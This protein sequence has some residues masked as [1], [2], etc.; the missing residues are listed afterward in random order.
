MDFFSAFLQGFQ[1]SLLPLNLGLIL[2]GSCVGTFVATL[3]GIKAIHCVAL[4][5]P[6]AYAL[7]LPVDSALVFLLM[8]YHGGLYGDRITTILAHPGKGN[9]S[10][11]LT[12]TC[13]GSFF[14]GTISLLGLAITMPL[15]NRI[16]IGFG[17]AEYFVLII[18]AFSTLS[19]QA[20]KYP[21]RTLISTCLGLMM[22]TIGIDSTTGILRFTLWQPQLYDGIAFTTVVIGIFVISQIFVLLENPDQHFPAV[23]AKSGFR[24]DWKKLFANRIILL[25]S[26]LCGFLIGTL[27]ACG[28]SIASNL[29][30]TLEKRANAKLPGQQPNKKKLLLARET[31]NNAAAGGT[32]V[33]LLTL[34]IPGS[35]TSAIL[36][37]ALLLYNITPGPTL[38]KQH[39]ELIWTI[40]AAGGIGN[41]VLLILNLSLPRLLIKVHQIPRQITLSFLL[42]LAFIS[43]FSVT[44]SHF[45]L[46]LMVILGLFGYLL[47][48]HHY[49]LVP[50]LLGFV[51]GELMENNLRRAL[52]ISAGE[53]QILFASPICK[54]FW[55]LSLIVILLPLLLRYR[56]GRQ[57]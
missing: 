31:A 47:Q 32:M 21:L 8:I 3:P 41:L 38:L 35:G 53:I 17:P 39:N 46:F 16:N 29:S 50:L 23:K 49:P 9:I 25:R 36:L 44:S 26:A 54:A 4:L 57:R 33:P 22:A 10:S 42:T 48:K 45:S 2:L 34:G 37:G 27:P 52:S 30:E 55:L 51:L 43:S 11:Q 56:K 12:L 24:P 18:F 5:T 1:I 19:I 40:I 13:L 7:R 28:T 15:I 6:I 20:G 14:G